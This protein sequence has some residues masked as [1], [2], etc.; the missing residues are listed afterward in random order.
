MGL[1]FIYDINGRNQFHCAEQLFE[2]CFQ[3]QPYKSSD[4]PVDLYWSCGVHK[5]RLGPRLEYVRGHHADGDVYRDEDS[6]RVYRHRD[7]GSFYGG[8]KVNWLSKYANADV[9]LSQITVSGG[10]HTIY[11]TITESAS[12]VGPI[13]QCTPTTLFATSYVTKYAPG[14]GVTSVKTL[15][16]NTVTAYQ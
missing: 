12:P 10:G 4:V 2:R 14:T 6:R 8:C 3:L 15:S 9:V 1:W 7:T 16:A 13:T 11:S 5:Q